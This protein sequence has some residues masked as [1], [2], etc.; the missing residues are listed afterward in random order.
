MLASRTSHPITA[1][2]IDRLMDEGRR[3]AG[4][5]LHILDRHPKLHPAHLAIE[6]ESA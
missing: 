2:P 1:Q 5:V 3:L 4:R 6:I